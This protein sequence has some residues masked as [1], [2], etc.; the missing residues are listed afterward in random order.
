MS[1]VKA[2]D[3]IEHS[4]ELEPNVK[5]IRGTI[6]KYTPQEREFANRI[7]PELEDAGIIARRSSPSGVRT[8]FPPKKKGSQLLLVV[9]N[10]IH[11]NRFTIKSAYPMHHL[12]EVLA[13]LIRSG[14]GV[15]FSS[16]AA[17][18]YWAVPMTKLDENKTEFIASNEQWVYLRMEQVLK[19][20]PFA[21]AQ[22]S[23]LVF[24]SL[25][26]N[27]VGVPRMP[28]L[29]GDRDNSSLVVF[30]DDHAASAI[31]FDT[32][33]ELLHIKYFRD[34]FFGPVYLSGLK[35]HLSSDILEIINFENSPIDLRP[36]SK[37]R[38]EIRSWPTPIDWDE[39]DA[40]LWL[41]SFLR[42]FELGRA[43]H[44]LEMKM[45]YL[46]Q[47]SDESKPKRSH[48][49]DMKLCDGNLGRASRVA[50]PKR[51]A[52]P[53]KWVSRISSMVHCTT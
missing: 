35:T 22:F 14:Y 4:I 33:F 44:V 21:Y 47:L 23:D 17:N 16:D 32:L 6:P 29:I 52:I 5:P 42:I 26:S 11:V 51:P 7:F 25:P 41:T 31:D 45:S 3:L 48:D 20:G 15:H 30:M 39:L 19:R 50:R 28:I 24:D 46:I 53:R 12:Q 27:A 34:A 49:D 10:F 18:G 40:F 38:E 1:D 37:H 2:T 13:I 9:H 43:E 36:S 8:R